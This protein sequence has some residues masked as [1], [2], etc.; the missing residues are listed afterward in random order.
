MS[1]D[2]SAEHARDLHRDALVVDSHSGLIV[3]VVRRRADG[4]R[5]VMRNV[6]LPRL[7]DGGVDIVGLKVGGDTIFAP[8]YKTDRHLNVALWNLEVIYQEVE[9]SEGE[10]VITTTVEDMRRAKREGKVG[11][12]LSFEGAR[13]IEDK[14]EFLRLF[15]RFG[16]RRFQLTW[17]FRNRIADGC[18]EEH[19]LGGVTQFGV[20]VLGELE[21]LGMVLDL[22]HLS[23]SSFWAVLEHHHGP[24][25]VSHANA[26]VL[27]DHPRNLS[28]DQIKAL[29]AR[30]GVVGV[31]FYG[32]FISKDEPTIAKL[33][34]HIDHIAGLVGVDHVGLGTDYTDDHY[35]LMGAGLSAYPDLYPE[36][37]WKKYPPNLSTYAETGNLTIELVQRGY[38]DAEIRKI[39]GENYLRVFDRVFRS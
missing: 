12:L 11:L 38:S 23:E 36:D 2:E 18:G 13:P 15:Y 21:K 3:D 22:A 31:V 9:E 30:G 6:H 14:L 25:L 19:A 29:A 20:Q 16:V 10:L 5:A 7:R 26:R 28:D 8:V 35:D 32:R 27:C 39:L 34:D 1:F 37:L 33:V 17:N 4:E 24:L